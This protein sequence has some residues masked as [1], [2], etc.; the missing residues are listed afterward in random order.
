MSW[1]ILTTYLIQAVVIIIFPIP[2]EASTLKLVKQ[3]TAGVQWWNRGLLV[4]LGILGILTFH[5]PLLFVLMPLMVPWQLLIFEGVD[6]V[7]NLAVVSICLLSGTG[8]SLLGVMA[9]W[10]HR[11]QIAGNVFT[12]LQ[13]DGIY[14]FCRHPINLGLM[15]IMT[16]FFMAYPLWVML[17]GALAFFY[18]L[19]IRACMEENYLTE[20]H[21]DNYRVYQLRVPMYGLPFSPK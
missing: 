20:Q 5:M 17:P 4:C 15:L 12:Q 3:N 2:S 10:R 9:Q 1:M 8:I 7:A 6:S 21:G 11:Q 13:T 14:G 18:N 19:H 16:G